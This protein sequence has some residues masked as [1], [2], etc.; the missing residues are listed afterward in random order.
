MLASIGRLYVC[1]PHGEVRKSRPCPQAR[2]TCHSRRGPGIS[3]PYLGGDGFDRDSE[4]CRGLY[5]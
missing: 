1:S 4:Q 3:L 5:K 2:E